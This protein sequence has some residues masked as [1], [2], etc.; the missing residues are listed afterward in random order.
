MSESDRFK[1]RVYGTFDRDKFFE[2]YKALWTR[3]QKGKKYHATEAE[4]NKLVL[5]HLPIVGMA[6]QKYLS[7][8][9]EHERE[10]IESAMTVFFFE[11]VREMSLTPFSPKA[12]LN[13]FLLSFRRHGWA[14]LR[15]QKKKVF[16]FKYQ[17]M[18]A[19]P[20]HTMVAT[21]DTMY[22]LLYEESQELI[23]KYVKSHLRLT[24]RMREACEYAY[25]RLIKGQ[26]ISLEHIR[27]KWK[28]K[29]PVQQRFIVELVTVLHRMA[30][31]HVAE[32][33]GYR[34]KLSHDTKVS[35]VN[36]QGIR[37]THTFKTISQ[38]DELL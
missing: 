35:W 30:M 31:Y 2:D 32:V 10:D 37:E 34:A 14:A 16:D 20:Y 1:L 33:H 15:E 28:I 19:P 3:H 21:D 27:K 24:G 11:K 9:E 22:R 29:G 13:Y 38:L 18:E 7:F 8:T 25:E 6:L 36:A 4:I 17:N 23:H 26:Y 12:L 5:T